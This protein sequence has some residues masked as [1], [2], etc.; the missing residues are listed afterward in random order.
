MLRNPGRKKQTVLDASF[1]A[2]IKFY[3]PNENTVN[4]QVSYYLKGSII[5]LA[6]DL[7]LRIQTNQQAS[8]DTIMNHLWREYG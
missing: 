3:Q 4:S 5:A 1:D 8:L 2:W 7:A 6:I